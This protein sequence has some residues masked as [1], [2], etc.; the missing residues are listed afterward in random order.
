M[1][2]KNDEEILEHLRRGVYVRLQCSPTH[3][4]GVFAIRNI[5]ANIDPFQERKNEMSFAMIPEAK[6]LD[7]PSIP[8]AVKEY[9]E[10]M[11]INRGGYLHF[12]RPGMNALPPVFYINHSKTP[13]VGADKEDYFFALREIKAGEELLIDYE[14]YNDNTGLP[15]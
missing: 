9:A 12:P 8:D 3:G 10:D 7:D 1:R 2:L 5:P 14:S 4:I 13:N 15:S 11:C 6:I